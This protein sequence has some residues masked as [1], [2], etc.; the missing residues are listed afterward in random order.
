MNK[1]DIK[2]LPRKKPQEPKW[3]QK[4]ITPD[5]FEIKQNNIGLF[6]AHHHAWKK[7]VWIGPY[8][9]E[10]EISKVIASYATVTKKP[11]GKRKEL[12]NVHS[13]IIEEKDW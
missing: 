5:Q 4:V 9:T 8:E 7:T 10:E 13:I 2:H 12:K 11:F 3:Y 1:N 6:F